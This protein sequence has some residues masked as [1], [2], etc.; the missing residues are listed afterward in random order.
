MTLAGGATLNSP[1]AG[2]VGGATAVVIPQFA[3]SGGWTTEIAL[4]NN[5]GATLVGRIDV[6]DAN[7]NPMPVNP[8]RR[9]KKYVQLFDSGWRHIPLGAKGLERP[10]TA[11]S[12]ISL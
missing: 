1:P 12:F 5:T 7:G 9:K 10:V 6:F 4:V 3:I 11:Y 2:T 8:K